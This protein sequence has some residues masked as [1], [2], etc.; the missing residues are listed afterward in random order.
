MVVEAGDEPHNQQSCKADVPELQGGVPAGESPEQT[1]FDRFRSAV[2]HL[3]HDEA[4]HQLAGAV[5]RL[6][7]PRL[8]AGADSSV[9]EASGTGSNDSGSAAAPDGSASRQAA[10]PGAGDSGADPSLP[11]PPDRRAP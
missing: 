7:P 8:P 2:G 9:S 5:Q 10:G 4:L 1:A 3:E 6:I 11:A